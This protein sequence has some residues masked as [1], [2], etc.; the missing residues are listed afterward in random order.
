MGK[1]YKDKREFWDTSRD[2]YQLMLI[3]GVTKANVH[4]DR[5]RE[6]NVDRCREKSKEWNDVKSM[7]GQHK[8]Y[9]KW[10][11]GEW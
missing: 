7:F 4:K 3:Q 2:I 8:K 10:D 6:K 5:K 1:T 9:V 11:G